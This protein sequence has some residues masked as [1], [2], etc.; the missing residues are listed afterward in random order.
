MHRF[1]VST[2]QNCST[3]RAQSNGAVETRFPRLENVTSVD[4]PHCAGRRPSNKHIGNLTNRNRQ[5]SWCDGSGSGC[6]GQPR[7]ATAARP[8]ARFSQGHSSSNTVR[9]GAAPAARV[10]RC[11]GWEWRGGGRRVVHPVSV[12]VPTRRHGATVEGDSQSREKRTVLRSAQTEGA[13]RVAEARQQAASAR[14][15]RGLSGRTVAQTGRA[16]G[17]HRLRR[18]LARTCPE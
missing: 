17:P 14:R 11:A 16:P 4:H 2:A 6:S 13:L 18:R 3:E 7:P 5:R 15:A 12:W 1:W 10:G 9:A 8:G